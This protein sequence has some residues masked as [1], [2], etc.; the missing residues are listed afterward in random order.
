MTLTKE[1]LHI[2]QH[3]LGVDEFGQGKM[4]RNHFCA[5]G[6]DETICRE[7]VTM[8][9]MTTFERSYL[10]YYNC[11]VTDAG[12]AAMLEQSPK[13][14]KLTR[15]QQ[16]YRRY[17]KA[18]TGFSFREFLETEKQNRRENNEIGWGGL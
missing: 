15:S 7:L 2:L 8:G 14:P 3:S 18:D 11:K 17:L 1:Q 16:R 5:G 9:L 10:P 6:G 4:Y 12:K 13:P